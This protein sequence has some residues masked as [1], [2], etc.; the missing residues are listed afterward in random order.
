VQEVRVQL[1]GP[2]EVVGSAGH[3]RLGGPKERC[4]IAALA[5]H[6]GE[7]LTE[8]QLVDALWEGDPPRTAA[9]TLQ[10]YVLRLRRRLGGAFIVTQ[11]PGYALTGIRTDVAEARD[12]VARAHREAD[13]GAHDVAASTFDEALALWRGAPFGE[14]ADRPFARAEAAGLDELHATTAE[15]RVDVLL[16][17]G[18][19]R[20]AVT[21]C[22]TLAAEQ[23]M[24]ERRCAQLMLALYRD[25][26]QSEALE[27]YRRLRKT[28]AD[29]LGV[30]PGAEARRL[31]ASILAHDPALQPPTPSGRVAPT[32][33]AMPCFG[34]EPEL[35]TLFEHLADVE[36]GRGRVTF[37]SGEPGIGKTRLLG[38][39]AIRLAERGVPVMS[40]RCLEGAGAP[41]FQAF[42]EAIDS[43]LDRDSAAP[44][45]ESLVPGGRAPVER[46]LQPDER[47]W[48]LL[49]AMARFLVACS[50]DSPVVLMLDDLHWADDGTVAMLRHVGRS[51][52]GTRLMV[53]GSYRDSDLTEGH[54]LADALGALRSESE[55][56]LLPL[57]GLDADAMRKLVSATAGATVSGALVDA[58][59]AETRGNPFFTREI[60]QHLCEDDGLRASPDG[61]VEARLPLAAIPEGVR[62]VIARRRR[63]LTR[64][65]NRLLDVAAA[66]E[67]P[68][69]FEPV[70]TAA[71]LSDTAALAAVDEALQAQLVVPDVTPDRYDFSHALIRHTVY[72]ELSPS[73]R[74]RL[75]RDLA[76]ALASFR[77]AGGR[78]GPAE[79]AVQFHRAASLPGAADGIGFALEAADQAGVTGAHDEQVTFLQIAYDLLPEGDA[80]RAQLLARR[81][82]ALAWALRFDEAVDSA[83]A[84]VAA[85][86]G[87]NLLADVAAVLATAGSTVHAWQLA[88]DGVA[89]DGI[90]AVRRAVLTLLDLDRKEAADPDHPGM[91]L[92]LPGRRDALRILHESGRLARRGDLTRYALAAM[93]G[94]R[95]LIPLGSAD[96]PTVAAFLL[97]DYAGAIPSFG[98]AAD[99]AEARG[100]LAWAVYCR[101]GEARCLIAV[102]ELDL[103]TI[104]LERSRGLVARLP[105]LPL[106]WQLLHHEGAEDALVSACDEGWPERMARFARWMRPGPERHWGSAGIT[107][108]GARG[109]ARIG[110]TE[111]ALSLLGQPV[112]ALSTAPAW[113]PNYA[114]TACEVAET[115]WL[116][117]RRDHLAV[118]ERA[119]RDK[120]LPADFRFPMTDARLALARLC[121]LDRRT[122]EAVQWFDSARSVL[123]AQGARPLR[124]VVDHDQ[125]VMHLRDGDPTAAAP[126]VAAAHA[127]F[128]RLKMTGWARRLSRAT[129]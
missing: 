101:S 117:D 18:R 99:D 76:E 29:E 78:V 3:V 128:G 71:G 51:T 7:T 26:R 17:A 2:V 87:A 66:V 23:P 84:A 21:E 36:T 97:G 88:A 10:N 58:I 37:V 112:R 20:E 116:L 41:P 49:D 60:V 77:G 34:R 38:T 103:A 50:A 47:R 95:D 4:L 91:Q 54:P 129:G 48:R 28:L 8:G 111:A 55:C 53:V 118:V 46:T 115:L 14:F 62:Q 121:A 80:R 86:S 43:H 120:A 13:R 94:R 81:S 96:D 108:I 16:A 63:R 12:L 92:D 11:R 68:F 65:T 127:E 22:E 109:Q 75:H 67:G 113:A 110:R 32:G 82:A 1:L 59:R 42:A 6:P 98:Q 64:T 102:G 24:R 107:S 72:R 70:K 125:A 93:Y 73:R 126:W 90:D 44:G 124:A 69:P 83:R 85:G 89:A 123:D 106:G 9:K 40:G 57:A 39:L 105:G 52:P 30:D 15:E 45:L 74:L 35:T 100:Q 122:I 119:L 114:R 19:H 104:A 79:V 27:A 25:G 33:T 31:E 61:T 5:V 56:A